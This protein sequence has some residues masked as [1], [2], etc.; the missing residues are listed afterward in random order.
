MFISTSHDTYESGLGMRLYRA[1]VYLSRTD[2]DV[3]AHLV[4]AIVLPTLLPPHSSPPPPPVGSGDAILDE[5]QRNGS[6]AHGR[7]HT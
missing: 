6:D 2:S 7:R 3:S 1:R 5:Y 4:L